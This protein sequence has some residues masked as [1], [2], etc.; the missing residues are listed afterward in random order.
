MSS[1]VTKPENV[2][3]ECCSFVNSPPWIVHRAISFVFIELSL[4]P[5]WVTS[6]RCWCL[7]TLELFNGPDWI[8]WMAC[9]E[10]RSFKLKTTFHK[11][12]FNFRKLRASCRS[13]DYISIIND[14]SSNIKS[15]DWTQF[16]SSC[17]HAAFS[18]FC[19]YLVWALRSLAIS[20]SV[21]TKKSKV[22]RINQ[23]NIF[24]RKMFFI[25]C[26][27]GFLALL[28]I[29]SWSHVNWIRRFLK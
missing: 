7:L 9:F 10:W 16:S 29:C 2:G 18:S 1:Y 22:L 13:N 11:T 15:Q 4:A 27:K 20:R 12:H 19:A 3:F 5:Y 6:L 21:G 24:E 23:P 25:R 26:L 28:D 14:E 8:N 17:Y